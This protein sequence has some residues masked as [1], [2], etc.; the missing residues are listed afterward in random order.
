MEKAARLAAALTLA[1]ASLAGAAPPAADETSALR[2]LADRSLLLDVETAGG[3][4]V[5]VGERGH[6]VLS[7]DQGAHWR[8]VVAPTTALLTG[9]AFADAKLGLAVGHDSTI[10]RTTDG[11]E[12]WQRVHVDAEADAPLFDVFF[13]DPARAFAVGAYG[14]F[15]ESAD[16]GATWAAR[17]ITESDA[18]YHHVSRAASGA[19]Y[20]AG[21]GG[22]LLR[23][24]D[25]GATWRELAV[26]YEGSLFGTLPLEGEALLLFGLRGHALSSPDGGRAWTPLET[27][28]DTMLTSA[29]R[30]KDGRLVMA[31]LAGVVLVS[32]DGGRSFALH[33]R[34]DRLG[35]QAMAATPDGGVVQCGEFGVRKLAAADVAAAGGTR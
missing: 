24:D 11:G 10:L 12:K 27:G 16:G 33:A 6:V 2:P 8:Q 34:P 26:P 21:E 4:L 17:P 29:V 25:A 31:G 3:R 20:L 22:L 15:L 1:L 9:V 18:H 14:S 35:V 19:L 28:V 30:L 32:G 5:A 13:V 7:D 23:S